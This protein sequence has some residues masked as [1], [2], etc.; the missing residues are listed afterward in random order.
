MKKILL[1][2]ANGF[3]G[4]NLLRTL[5]AKY[6]I[7]SPSSRDLDLRDV[8]SV[9][10]FF[11]NNK[12]D[13]V[14]H[15][16]NVGGARNEV[17]KENV[18]EDNLRMFFNLVRQE[19]KFEKMIYF[20]SGAEYGKQSEI[21][22]LKEEDLGIR[23]PADS[24]GFYKYVCANYT[25]NSDKLVNLRLFGVY[26]KYE[27][28]KVRFIS[29]TICKILLDLPI[30]IKQNVVFE[31]LYIEDLVRVVEFF[32]ENNGKHNTYNVGNGNKVELLEVAK[33]ILQKLGKDLPLTVEN[34]GLNKEYTADVSR[35]KTE[36]P[37]DF[38]FTDLDEGVENLI[39][40]YKKIIGDINKED[41]FD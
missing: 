19:D 41:F 14:I 25:L 33:L 8:E 35:L 26:G 32:L 5:S 18:V 34:E 15:T 3:I 23:M 31:Y 38:K 7:L 1:T 21:K 36:L 30:K 13:I 24:Y 40:F 6:E 29:Q 17:G 22:S 28:Y 12:V 2:G 11:Q 9:D 39:N 20:G 4:K 27:D 16:A 10:K 37:E